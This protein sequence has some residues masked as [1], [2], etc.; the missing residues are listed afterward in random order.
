MQLAEQEEILAE[1]QARLADA[2]E[3]VPRLDG[4]RRAAQERVQAEAAQIHQLEARL[5]AL[6]QL[7]ENVQTEG[8][9]QPWL[10][11]HGSA[12]CR[13]C[14]RSCMSKPAGKPRSRP[15]CASASPRS[16]CRISTG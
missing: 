1:A 9:V 11:K 5:A 16:K 12:R 2:Q 13:V 15:C 8:K 14:G 3:T 4:E 10:D 7:Q 6:K